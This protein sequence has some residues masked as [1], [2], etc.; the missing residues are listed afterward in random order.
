MLKEFFPA[1]A[2]HQDF[3]DRNPK[4]TYIVQWDLPKIEHLKRDVPELISKK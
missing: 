2:Y 3:M 1:E 4:N